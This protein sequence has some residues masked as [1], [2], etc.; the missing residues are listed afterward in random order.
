MASKERIKTV[1]ELMDAE[2]K[3]G[4]NNGISEGYAA[5]QRIFLH[6]AANHKLAEPFS[7]EKL[8]E[9][10]EKDLE[11]LKAKMKK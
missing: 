11:Q 7:Q 2:Y 6:Y 5:A 9:W 3:E 4:Y 10:A 8:K 1:T